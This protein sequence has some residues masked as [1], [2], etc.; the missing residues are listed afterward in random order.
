M[1]PALQAVAICAVGAALEGALAGRGVR[2]RFAELRQPSFSPSLTSWFAIGA[3]YYVICFALLYRLLATDSATAAH[4]AAVAVLLALMAM[5]AGWGW[6]FFRRKD[7][8]GSFLAFFPYTLLALALGIL[9]LRLDWI[10]ALLLLPYLLYL[11]YA[12]WW[13]H[14]LWALNRDPARAA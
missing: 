9:L 10:A 4:R 1:H 11:G 3:V 6:L 5:N 8:R 12:L 13:S 7:L 2:A 14:R